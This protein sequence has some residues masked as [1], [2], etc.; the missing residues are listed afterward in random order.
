M[1]ALYCQHGCTEWAAAKRIFLCGHHQ[2]PEL[3]VQ[4]GAASFRTFCAAAVAAADKT[5]G[6]MPLQAEAVGSK[7][8]RE[9]CGECKGASWRVFA[10]G[11]WSQ[12]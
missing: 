11:V 12:L 3:D 7:R 10:D 2:T 5:C 4:S 1:S 6:A 8:L 9:P